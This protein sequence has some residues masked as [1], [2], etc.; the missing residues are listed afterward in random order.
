MAASVKTYTSTTQASAYVCNLANR[1]VSKAVEDRAGGFYFPVTIFGR[2]DSQVF[3]F[4]KGDKRGVVYVNLGTLLT[5]RGDVYNFKGDIIGSYKDDP[6]ALFS[7]F[8]EQWAE[9]GYYVRDATTPGT[10]NKRIFNISSLE[11][12]ERLDAH[13]DGWLVKNAHFTPACKQE[14]AVSAPIPAALPVASAPTGVIGD[15][16]VTS[17]PKTMGLPGLALATTAPNKVLP[18]EEKWQ[19]VGTTVDTIF[20]GDTL[21]RKQRRA[22]RNQLRIAAMSQTTAPAVEV[23]TTAPAVEVQ[24]TAP[25][26]EVQ[27]TA[28]AVEVQTTAPAVEVQTT[29]AAPKLITMTVAELSELIATTV[30]AAL[31]KFSSK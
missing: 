19:T 5:G 28:P 11:D 29:E 22:V 25:A 20:P 31:M 10:T 21:N 30:S 12:S 26:V 6:T 4:P 23:Q 15:V 13:V 8:I 1:L 18:T 16:P 24:T 9:K 27:T 7:Q 17:K 14:K 3:L 2:D